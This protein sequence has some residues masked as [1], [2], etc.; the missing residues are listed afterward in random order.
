MTT[1]NETEIET[2]IV[3]RKSKLYVLT[4]KKKS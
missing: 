2:P 1:S 4:L 3:E